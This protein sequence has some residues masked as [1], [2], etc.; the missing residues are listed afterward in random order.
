[1]GLNRGY[2]RPMIVIGGNVKTSGGSLSLAKGQLALIDRSKTTKQGA[3]VVTTTQGKPKN[4][5]DFVIRCGISDRTPDRSHSNKNAS[6]MP[7]SLDQVRDLRV[8]APE[9]TERKVDEVVIGYDGFDP[10][11][12]FNF[13]TGDA[14]LRLT[15]ELEG[16]MV[17][18]RGS[19]GTKEIV[20]VNVELPNCDPFD[21]CEDC[22]ECDAVDCKAIVQEVIERLK[23]K[24]L[25]G[26]MLVEEVVDITP[27]LSCDNPAT[28]TEIDYNFYC[29]EVCDTGTEEALAFVDAQYDAK[30]FRV[31][32]TGPTSKYQLMVP[33]TAGAPS[34][35][36]QTIASIIKG[37]E[38]CPAGYDEVPGG[39]V[40]SVTIEDDGTD[41][42]AVFEGNIP[43]IVAGTT[44]NSGQNYGVGYYTF[45]TDDELT[46]AEIATFLGLG[47]PH[48]TAT[49][50]KP[51]LVQA[52]CENDDT[53]ETAWTACGSCT[54]I[55]ERYT[56]VLPD[57]E[58]GEDRLAELNSNYTQTVTIA[59]TAAS[60]EI[61]LAGTGGDANVNIDGTDYLATFN[62]DLTTTANDFVAAHATDIATNHGYTV[63]ANAG[64][65]TFT[66]T[67][68]VYVEPTIANN[69]G[70]LD[71]TVATTYT[72]DAGGC[73]RRYEMLV[74]S[75]LVCE[76]CDPVFEDY[77]RT[78]APE[79]FDT[80]QWELAD[81]S[82]SSPNGNC[83][84][85]IRVKGKTFDLQG[86]LALRQRVG[87]VETSTRVRIA[88]D[89][90]EE[91]RE[92]I[93]RIPD[94]A[95]EGKYL[96]RWVQRTHLGGNLTG[97]ECEGRHYFNGVTKKDYLGQV[98]RGEISNIEDE[99]K[100]YV[101]YTLEI[102]HKNMTQGF[103]GRINDVINY[104]IF[105]EV[106]RHQAVEAL[107][108][109]IAANAGVDPV[110]AFGA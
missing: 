55:E 58:C 72:E 108:N 13:K 52:I 49:F 68:D 102:G 35:Y 97:L 39:F 11:T 91:I 4:E 30:V 87:Y 27:V 95:R 94:G 93:G 7:F 25:S 73:Q 34:N 81:N 80:H 3:K 32:R 74:I 21:N 44:V 10:S 12:S 45:V 101:H 5:K 106:G 62:T 43:G 15:L 37:C 48:S 67:T 100:Q 14:Y 107:L 59:Y 98:L 29:L 18:W 24:Q 38:D 105:V 42:T 1:M 61:T 56:I 104:D 26:G 78:D 84:C 40:Y 89:Y 75:N 28:A 20:N 36:V 6:T 65:L 77:Y 64:V 103:A 47:D 50:G 17:E 2:D 66:A 88:A 31:D 70:D 96:S 82:A 53:T 60:T 63:T 76:E 8:S 16:A 110:Q 57:N 85:G 92:G 54:A 33:A 83:L 79:S 51:V 46:D 90:P 41:L 69:S 99:T 22:D 19:K 86:E 109:D 71:G 23:R 9:H